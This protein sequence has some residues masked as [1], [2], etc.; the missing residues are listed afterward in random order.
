MNANSLFRFL[1]DRSDSFEVG[2]KSAYFTIN[3]LIYRY[4]DHFSVNSNFDIS[5]V[6]SS[7]LY[8]ITIKNY[9]VPK[10]YAKVADVKRFIDNFIFINK[11]LNTQS[12]NPV[13]E[14]VEYNNPKT[15]SNSKTYS[16]KIKSVYGFSSIPQKMRT[17]IIEHLEKY[18]DDYVSISL[19]VTKYSNNKTIRDNGWAYFKNNRK[20]P[21]DV[22]I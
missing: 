22:K 15:Y 14:I 1:K 2:I 17:E 3:K 13:P 9:Q 4:S 20:F 19:F 18:S 12:E 21:K 16:E 10:V 11:C 8:I 6:K 7:G 5:V